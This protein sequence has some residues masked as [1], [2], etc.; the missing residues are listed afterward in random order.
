MVDEAVNQG[1]DWMWL[2]CHFVS[3]PKK[4]WQ[5]ET[6]QDALFSPPGNE[7]FS[8]QFGAISL[9]T[10]TENLEKGKINPLEKNS[11]NLVETAPPKLQICPLSWSNASWLF[12]EFFPDIVTW[13]YAK[14]WPT[15]MKSAWA[16]LS[17]SP[18]WVPPPT[19]EQGLQMPM[20]SHVAVEGPVFFW[21]MQ[22]FCLQLEASCLQWSFFTYNWHFLLCYLQSEL[23]TYNFSLFAYC[24]AFFAYNG[25]SVSNKRLN[26][27]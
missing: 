26:G 11:I 9:L 16:G 20:T 19:E 22:L 13:S 2:N 27:L 1:A 18:S 17:S 10:Y 14:S 23:C 3:G 24:W 4:P 21:G 7:Q 12:P 15:F 8:P 25:E 6:W 5:P